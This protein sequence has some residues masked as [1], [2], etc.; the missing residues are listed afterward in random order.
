MLISVLERIREIGTLRSVGFT[1]RQIRAMFMIEAGSLF[2]AGILLAIP[3]A[4]MIQTVGTV[5]DKMVIGWVLD[6]SIPWVKNIGVAIAMALVVSLSAVYPAWLA[7]EV[8]PVK[9]LRSQ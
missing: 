6:V 1:R 7:T 3:V 9:A 4:A 5:F 2:L 8:D